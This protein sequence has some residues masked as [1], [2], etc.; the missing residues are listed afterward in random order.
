MWNIVKQQKNPSHHSW[1]QLFFWRL[2]TCQNYVMLSWVLCLDYADMTSPSGAIS[3]NVCFC[4]Q[5]TCFCLNCLI[6]TMFTTIS[7]FC[8]W[9][10]SS[11]WLRKASMLCGSL[12]QLSRVSWRPLKGLPGPWSEHRYLDS[13]RAATRQRLP[14]SSVTQRICTPFLPKSCVLQVSAAPCDGCSCCCSTTTHAMSFGPSAI[15]REIR[16]RMSPLKWFRILSMKSWCVLLCWVASRFLTIR[17]SHGAQ[18]LWET[19]ACLNLWAFCGTEFLGWQWEM[20]EIWNSSVELVGT[21]QLMPG[22]RG[23]FERETF[24]Q[25]SRGDCRLR[26]F[27]SMEWPGS[28]DKSKER[29]QASKFPFLSQVLAEVFCI[30]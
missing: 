30:K 16:I 27:P 13:Q 28:V 20:A 24:M 1:H 10:K 5:A 25:T 18:A 8:I 11:T 14:E 17:H 4:T 3:G 2:K 15:D 23:V 22:L 29:I 26:V 12:L 19:S 21:M 7:S 6:F 9:R